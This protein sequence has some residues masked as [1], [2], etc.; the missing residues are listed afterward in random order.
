MQH[1]ALMLDIYK[2]R[3]SGKDTQASGR[4]AQSS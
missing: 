4:S 1:K 2:R 3:S